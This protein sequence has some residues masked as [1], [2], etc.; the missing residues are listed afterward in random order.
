MF[1]ASLP[2]GPQT[3]GA[4]D[5]PVVGERVVR[6]GACHAQI[7]ADVAIEVEEIVTVAEAQIDVAKHGRGVVDGHWIVAVATAVEQVVLDGRVE[8]NLVILGTDSPGTL[9]FNRERYR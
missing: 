1:R 4:A 5:R 8:G 7:A 6:I 3:Y 9:S 2:I